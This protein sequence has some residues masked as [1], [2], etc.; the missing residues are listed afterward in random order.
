MLSQPAPKVLDILIFVDAATAI[1]DAFA[2]DS[3]LLA[4]LFE[5]IEFVVIIR[6]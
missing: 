1:L 6:R 4:L 2:K 3:H 5:L